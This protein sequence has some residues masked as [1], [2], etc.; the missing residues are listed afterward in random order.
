MLQ[1]ILLK[2]GEKIHW[3]ISDGGWRIILLFGLIAIVFGVI[4]FYGTHEFHWGYF[5]CLHCP[6]YLFCSWAL[7][8]VFK[9][10]KNN[11]DIFK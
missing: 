3:F 7:Y 2:T 9:L 4:G 5:L 8:K 11:P 1:K 6:I 10:I